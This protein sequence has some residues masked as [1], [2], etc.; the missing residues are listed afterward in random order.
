MRWLTLFRPL[1]AILTHIYH[2]LSMFSKLTNR[3]Y[4]LAL[5]VVGLVLL[6][7][8]VSFAFPGALDIG[9]AIFSFFT[10]LAGIAGVVLNLAVIHLVV[11]MGGLIKGGFGA[12]LESTWTIIRDLVNLAFIFGL[13][14]IGFQVMLSNAGRATKL[15]APLI[16]AALL[17]NFSL[18]FTKVVIDL[19]NVAAVEIYDTMLNASATGVDAVG[20]TDEIADENEKNIGVS[21]LFMSIMGLKDLISP[22]SEDS[23]SRAEFEETLTKACGGDV[24]DEQKASCTNDIFI[25]FLIG[26]IM[27]LVAAYAFLAGAMLLVV[28][29]IT[30]VMLMILSPVMFLGMAFPLPALKSISN[31]WFSS[32]WSSAFMAPVFFLLLYIGLAVGS[33]ANLDP[34]K[35][36]YMFGAARGEYGSIEGV[37]NLIIVTAFLLMAVSTGRSMAKSASSATMSF[38]DGATRRGRRML[39]GA[40]GRSVG[41][42]GW[43]GRNTV[44]RQASRLAESDSMKK[45]AASNKL[46]VG[47]AG[48]MAMRTTRGVADSSFDARRVM[49]KDAQKALGAGQKKG[50]V[51]LTKDR[52][53]EREKFAES[54]GTRDVGLKK[55]EY[56]NTER[57]ANGEVIYKDAQVDKEIKGN[58]LVVKSREELRAAE[59]AEAAGTDAEKTELKKKTEKAKANLQKATEIAE[60]SVEYSRQINYK[61]AMESVDKVNGAIAD[62]AT[63]SAALLAGI[64]AGPAIL[65]GAGKAAVA[66]GA[67]AVKGGIAAAGVAG[68]AVAAAPVS[69]AAGVAAGAASYKWRDSKGALHKKYGD[70]GTKAKKA[71]KKRDDLKI[72]SDEIKESGGSDSGGDDKKDES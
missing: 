29:F 63:G 31:R 10:M 6:F 39:Y 18:L 2:K 53:K 67:L 3:K 14:Y 22:S 15:L 64:V 54:L 44:G 46:G 56:G 61:K 65:V 27:M 49:G 19:T 51:S 23:K 12:S 8:S 16:I 69:T 71:K 33:K 30:L 70:D 36:I 1:V 13:V 57:D 72:L 45:W 48:R 60:A 5:T 21:G 66:G 24:E 28:R 11:G 68:S 52:D 40:T 62:A 32:L 26:S 43:A 50:Y 35:P 38:A 20:V 34:D 9:L 37:L 47:A 25:Y 55:D 58:K 4:K 42:A 17:V 59:A 7:P 41:A